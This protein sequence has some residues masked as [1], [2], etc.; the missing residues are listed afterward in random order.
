MALQDLNGEDVH[1]DEPE[2][3]N[4]EDVSEVVEDGEN[5]EPMSEEDEDESPENMTELQVEDDSIQGFFEHKEPV[6][7][8]A[9]HP[10]EPTLVI[11]GG[12]D[13][14]AYLWRLDTGETIAELTAHSDSVVVAAFSADGQYAATGGM[15]GK[16]HVSAIPSGTAV[17]TLEGPTEITWIGW[18]PR[19]PVLVAGSEDGTVWM[20]KIPSGQCMNVFTGHVESSTCGQFSP[21]G[22][23][24]VTG[25]TD[26]SLIHWDPSTATAK[27]KI[28]GED[29]RFH[30]AAITS[31]AVHH[32][33]QLVL[34]GAQDGT[35]RLV[36]LGNGRILAAFD[37]H[38]ESIESVGFSK[39]HP[40]AATSSVDG[41]IT[42]WD[43]NTLQS[44]V[45]VRHT[46]A[47]TQI[48]WHPTQPLLI[49]ASTDRTIKVWDARTGECL[50]TWKGHEDTVL[51]FGITADGGKVVSGSDDGV[52]LVFA[53]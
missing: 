28:T 48:K 29:A 10:I 7:A 3:I 27:L 5:G 9:T 31:L 15:D 52:A 18:H 30:S 47:V 4:P 43:I 49:S 33:N 1:D 42:I 37:S 2:F 16:I 23:T 12:G 11:S 32:D 44:R 53:I 34:T 41:S 35:A 21:D 20:W 17:V 50:K 36:H 13:D 6:Y 40:F 46:D 25:S 22:K 38:T 39:T 14:K 24:I 51:E 8:V 26:G 45:S 19:G